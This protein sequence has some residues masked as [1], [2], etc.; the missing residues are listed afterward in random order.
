[1]AQAQGWGVHRSGTSPRIPGIIAGGKTGGEWGKMGKKKWGFA[2]KM[3]GEMGGATWKEKG[4]SPE[5][6]T[7]PPVPKHAMPRHRG[8]VARPDFPHSPCFPPLSPIFPLLPL[9]LRA[10]HGALGTPSSILPGASQRCQRTL[11]SGR[12][13]ASRS[14]LLPARRSR[15]GFRCCAPSCHTFPR[16][17]F[18]F[19]PGV[20]FGTA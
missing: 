20:H 2:G 6:G 18:C 5:M 8:P 14:V 13:Q 11:A 9:F 4:I 7:S 19:A 15:I 12:L 1:M 16:C 10:H 17:P 3:G